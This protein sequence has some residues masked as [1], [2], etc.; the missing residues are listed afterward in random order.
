[1]R[2][3]LFLLLFAGSDAAENIMQRIDKAMSEISTT[4][5]KADL[6]ATYEMTHAHEGG[7]EKELKLNP[8]QQEA[9]QNLEAQALSLHRDEPQRS[10][11]IAGSIDAINRHT[12]LGE[13]LYQGDIVLDIEQARIIAAQEEKEEISREKRQAMNF[14][15]GSKKYKWPNATVTYAIQFGVDKDTKEVFHKAA[16]QWQ[17]HTCVNFVEDRSAKERVELVEESGCFSNMG[18]LGK[19]QKLSLGYGCDKVFK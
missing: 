11:G 15:V 10:E 18:Y 8:Q 14:K 6:V 9:L 19:I 7:V 16:N 17:S 5:N 13:F 2:I 3:I 12:P 4:L 1:M